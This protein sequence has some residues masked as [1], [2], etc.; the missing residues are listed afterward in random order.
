MHFGPH[1]RMSVLVA[2]LAR[3]KRSRPGSDKIVC[4]AGW[5]FCT[6]WN[7]CITSR[8]KFQCNTVWSELLNNTQVTLPGL[9]CISGKTALLGEN[10][11]EMIW[12]GILNAVLS[13]IAKAFDGLPV[14]S[15]SVRVC[16]WAAAGERAALCVF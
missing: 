14:R 13:T 11:V 10:L 15:C 3:A 4:K 9:T 16:S 1:F 12:V 8:Y 5:F 2:A 7:S 6:D